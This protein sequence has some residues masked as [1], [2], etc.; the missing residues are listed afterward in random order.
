V[1]RKPRIRAS[2]R[3]IAKIFDAFGPWQPDKTARGHAI[4][5]LVVDEHRFALATEDDPLAVARA[6]GRVYEDRDAGRLSR[7][8]AS[9][10]IRQLRDAYRQHVAGEIQ[11]RLERTS[12]LEYEL[13][14]LVAKLRLHFVSWREIAELLGISPQLAHY[15]YRHVTSESRKTRS[16]ED[17]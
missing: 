9:R 1:T 2:L 3:D 11:T 7:D 13:E 8:D 17:A 12:Q 5:R 6:V 10:D 14:Y 4:S 15:R 16:P